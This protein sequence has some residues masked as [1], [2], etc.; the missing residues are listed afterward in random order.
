MSGAAEWGALGLGG[1]VGGC[2]EEGEEAEESVDE[3][4]AYGSERG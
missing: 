1:G 3:D 4:L 2:L